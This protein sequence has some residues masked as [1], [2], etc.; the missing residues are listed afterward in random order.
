MQ[1]QSET[2]KTEVRTSL[3][4]VDRV[5]SWFQPATMPEVLFLSEALYDI[6]IIMQ[7]DVAKVTFAT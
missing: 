3:F 4:E 2:G 5:S 7:H 6:Q 1:C